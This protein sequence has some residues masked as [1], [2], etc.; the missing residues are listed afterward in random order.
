MYWKGNSRFLRW[1]TAHPI[2]ALG[3]HWL[4]QSIFYLDRTELAFKLGLE[5]LLVTPVFLLLRTWLSLPLA[6]AISLIF[7]HSL[8]FFLN[9]HLWNALKSFGYV[10][11]ERSAFDAYVQGIVLRARRVAAIKHLYLVG[12]TLRGAWSPASDLD[13]RILRHPGLA[14]GWH[15]CWFL[16]TERSRALL[17]GFPLDAYVLDSP[18][19]LASLRE[20]DQVLDLLLEKF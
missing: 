19:R 8:N 13:I 7:A 6:F 2:T 4:F 18:K 14:N 1:L 20:A 11:F 3:A 15:A 12:S 16:L 10:N 17:A 5:I 9:A